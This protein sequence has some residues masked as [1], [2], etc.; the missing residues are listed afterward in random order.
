SSAANGLLFRNWMRRTLKR[1]DVIS[2]LP[3]EFVLLQR[4]QPGLRAAFHQLYCSSAEDSFSHGARAMQG[5]DLLLGN[6]ATPTNNHLDAFELLRRLDLEGR[7]IVVPLSYGVESYADA[8]C[9]H[10][11]RLFGP[12]FV[13]LRGYLSP[14]EYSERIATC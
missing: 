10:G 3:E 8:V 2:M 12:R 11:H 5:P 13:P 6:S 1:I 9:A 7:N 14:A 4:S